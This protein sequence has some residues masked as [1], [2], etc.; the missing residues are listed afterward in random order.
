MQA[1]IDILTEEVTC[2][3]NLLVGVSNNVEDQKMTIATTTKVANN[4]KVNTTYLE[5]RSKEEVMAATFAL[6]ENDR[7]RKIAQ[8][9]VTTLRSTNNESCATLK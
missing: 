9:E 6:Q 7:L 4:A 1:K 8:D 3:N 2:L 5:N